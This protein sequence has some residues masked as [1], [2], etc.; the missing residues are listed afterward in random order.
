MNPGLLVPFLNALPLDKLAKRN[1]GRCWPVARKLKS[2][3]AIGIGLNRMEN[4]KVSIYKVAHY[5][6]SY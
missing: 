1:P 4:P 2:E 3:M 5:N 6:K